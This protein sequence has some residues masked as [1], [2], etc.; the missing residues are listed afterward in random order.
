MNQGECAFDWGVRYERLG[1]RRDKIR[2]TQVEKTG[3]KV[4]LVEGTDDANA[5]GILLGG[6]PLNAS[7]KEVST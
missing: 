2:E 5:Y 7:L 6:Y 1:K 4:I 3:K